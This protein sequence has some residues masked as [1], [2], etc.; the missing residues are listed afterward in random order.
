MISLILSLAL[1]GFITYLVTTLLPMP[2][3]IRSIIIAV[4]CIVAL[5]MV[6]GAFGVRTP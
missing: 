5:F 1:L 2:A 3:Q 4:A 6:L